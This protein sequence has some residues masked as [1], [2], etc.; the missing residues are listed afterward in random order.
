MRKV[1]N[2]QAILRGLKDFQRDT[3]ECVFRRL[4]LDH[5][6]TD[7]FLVADE[8]GLGKTLVA[9]GLIARMTEHLRNQR[10]IDVIYVCSNSDIAR[11]NISRLNIVGNAGAESTTRITML[12]VQASELRQHE[13]NFVSFTPGTALDLKSR[14][15]NKEERAVLFHLLRHAWR[16]D[17]GR[18]ERV[19]RCSC[20]RA[21]FEQALGRYHP[22]RF[23][24]GLVKAFVRY[25]NRDQRINGRES[26]RHRFGQLARL[27]RTREV[28]VARRRLVGDLRLALAESCLHALK[29]DLIILDEFQRFRDLLDPGN[30]DSRLAQALFRRRHAKILLLSATPYKMYTVDGEDGENH[31]EDFCKTVDFLFAHTGNG[32][33]RDTIR[34]YRRELQTFTPDDTRR[35]RGIQNKLA[36]ELR[37]V[38]VRTERLAATPNRN[39]MLEQIAA[40]APL[41]PEYVRAF[42]TFAGAA[43]VLKNGSM[44]EYWKSA[45][46]LLNFMDRESYDFKAEFRDA[47]NVPERERELAALLAGRR[48]ALLSQPDIKAY[49]RIDPGNTRL[50]TLFDATVKRN[51]WK[52]LWIPPALQYYG[53][54]PPFQGADAVKKLLVFSSWRVVPKVVAALLSYEAER[55]IA[56]ACNQTRNS[57]HARK[58][59]ANLLRFSHSRG[60]LASMPLFGVIYPS[61]VLAELADPLRLVRSRAYAVS[62]DEALEWAKSR[63]DEPLQRL[64]NSMRTQ[65][66]RTLKGDRSDW[67]WAAPLLLDAE[68]DR[69]RVKRFLAALE[70]PSEQE[71]QDENNNSASDTTHRSSRVWVAHVRRARSLLQGVLKLGTPPKDLLDVLARMALAGPGVVALRSL[72]RIGSVSERDKLHVHRCAHRIAE[73]FRRMLSSPECSG[74]LR[75]IYPKQAT[76]RSVLHYCHAGGFQTVMD[77]YVHVLQESGVRGSTL[78]KQRNEIAATICSALGLRTAAVGVDWISVE[79]DRIENTEGRLRT[80]FAAQFSDG[81]D[82]DDEDRIARKEQLRESFNSPFWPFVLTTTSAG[83]EGLDFHLYCHS[84]V[85]WNLPSNPVDLEQREGR[86]H[87]YKGHAVR[88]NLAAAYAKADLQQ[89]TDPW[90]T[91]FEEAAQNRKADCDLEPYWVLKGN[92]RIERHLPFLPLSREQRQLDHLHNAL[93]LYRMVFGQAHQQDLVAELSKRLSEGDIQKIAPQLLVD[94][95]PPR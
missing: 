83:Q 28:S 11:Q 4:Y 52:M 6:C 43:K 61:K 56:T 75:A 66:G 68:R 1:P 95:S 65:S 59:F 55:E 29:P 48:E 12:P 88:K 44:I 72:Q 40:T 10:R 49:R 87:R 77:E 13:F 5:D 76:W 8:V 14:S 69:E 74:V 21:G 81:T 78:R 33:Y 26:L 93:W 25:L 71:Q 30:P 2:T 35:L 7:R 34:E 46:Y 84:V 64:A 41:R 27:D 20:S 19:L 60:R 70:T 67:Y 23:D 89:A 57:Q 50:A 3:V 38:M 9:Q 18:A 53:C 63:L 94:L 47:L 90:K 36:N 80:R 24:L 86:V 16:L 15:G 91:M 92:A 51:A 31:H 37:R 54:A 32:H 79:G 85:H 82:V 22:E 39:G 45:P 17:A 62:A 42:V 58:Q 73:A